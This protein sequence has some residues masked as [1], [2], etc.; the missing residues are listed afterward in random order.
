MI[1]PNPVSGRNTTR[2]RP[3]RVLLPVDL[4]TASD[5]ALQLT[6]NVGW[7]AGS[8]IVALTAVDALPRVAGERVSVVPVDTDAVVRRFRDAAKRD[9]REA[10]RVRR[11]LREGSPA[12][13]IVD[14]ARRLRAMLIVVGSG[15]RGPL[16]TAVLGSVAATVAGRSDRPVL[17]AR[18]DD[19]RRILL[20]DDG[21]CCAG[22]AADWLLRSPLASDREL[23]VISVARAAPGAEASE[24]GRL[25]AERVV[26]DRQLRLAEVGIEAEGVVCAGDPARTILDAA[27]GWADLIVVGCWGRTGLRRL[28][29]GSVARTVMTSAQCSVL[30]V[31]EASCC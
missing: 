28:L 29:L 30:V 2:A 26:R 27:A 9:R 31:K 14:A 8:S 24:P 1:T 23:R 13:V 21:S 16:E 19:V 10:P 22:D 20:A 11:I 3:I 17:V 18:R 25:R 5:A 7:P 15:R 4:S 6:A 12:R